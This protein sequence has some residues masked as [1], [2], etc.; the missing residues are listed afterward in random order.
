MLSPEEMGA[1]LKVARETANVTQ[2]AAA[3]AAGMARTT[4]VGLENGQR[5]ARI[6]EL[7]ALGRHYGVSVNF[8][9]RREAVHVDLLPRFRSL[10]ETSDAAIDQA[11]RL[12]NDLVR[13]EVELENILGIHRTHNYPSEKAILPGD[14]RFQAEHDAQSLRNFL[15][16]GESPIQNLFAIMEFQLG[17]RIYSR[18][19]DP[20]ISGLFA[21]DD[22]VGACIL[23][24]SSHRKD[25][26]TQT[27]AHELGHFTATRRRPEIYQDEKL[28]NSKEERYANAFGRAFLTPSRAVMEKFREVTTGGSH[29]TRRHIILLSNF[30]GVSRQAMV[31]RLEELG[32]TKKG[33][34][35]WFR[36]KGNIT[37]EQARQVLGPS[38]YDASIVNGPQSCRLFLLAIDAWKRGLISEEQ[39]SEML[40]LGRIEVRELIDEAA[41][42][43][44]EAD[45]ILKLPH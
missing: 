19:L 15:G 18:R 45:D 2:D 38:A 24:N 10:P 11:A 37:E 14:V 35:N 17:V 36:D 29:L 20:R 33:T 16:L 44:D 6:E 41:E 21:Y 32:L 43:E 31:K 39:M 22:A 30:F 27:G 3:K 23:V 9:L 4:L 8:L 34:W 42:D 28:D 5:P 26:L 25:R 40:K 1:R 7:L 12:L 13:A